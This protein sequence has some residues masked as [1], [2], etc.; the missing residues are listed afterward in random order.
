[1]LRTTDALLTQGHN[2]SFET[3]NRDLFEGP[4]LPRN[5]LWP[6]L[7]CQVWGSK[8]EDPDN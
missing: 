8:N 1:M 5:L 2:G 7:N 4:N 6:L 3:E